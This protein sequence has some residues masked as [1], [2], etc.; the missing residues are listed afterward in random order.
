MSVSIRIG[1]F[2]SRFRFRFKHAS[3]DRISTENVI[4]EVR[5]EHGIQGYG[6]GCP[7]VY[8]TGESTPSA[9]DF[10]ARHSVHIVRGASTL[11]AFDDLI[12]SNGRKIDSHPAAFCALEIALIDLFARRGGRP[13]EALLGLPPLSGTVN[14][15]GIIGDGSPRKTALYSLVYRSL[16]LGDFKVKLGRDPAIDRR[17]FAALPARARIRVDANNLFHDS[18]E[19][20]RHIRALKRPIWAVEEPLA[21][22]DFDNMREV[23]SE[24]GCRIILDESLTRIDQLEIIAPDPATWVLNLR[25][26]KCGGIIRTNALARAAEALGV[27]VIIGAHVGETSLLTRAALCAGQAL[28]EPALAREGAFGDVL[29]ASDLTEPSIRFGRRGALS[30]ERKTYGRSPGLGLKV[31]SD[32]I[33]WLNAFDA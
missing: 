28:A 9:I 16:G 8:V 23:A 5:D 30:L 33:R 22:G 20:V 18:G 29:L 17:R 3:A 19:C 12:M 27:G 6:E 1:C 31:R 2:D 4:V 10:L 11:R 7:R 24:L 21:A 32:S 13:V 26:S 14:Y 15:S 25:V